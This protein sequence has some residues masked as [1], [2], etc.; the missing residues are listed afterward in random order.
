MVAMLTRTVITI[1]ASSETS[2]SKLQDIEKSIARV[3]MVE[4]IRVLKTQLGE[5]LH[6]VREETLRQKAD[7]QTAMEALQHELEGSRERMGGTLLRAE[8]G[9]GHRACRIRT[10]LSRRS[11]LPHS[12]PKA[13]SYC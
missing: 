4:D 1:G 6:T 11:R 2:V 12:R 10:R 5:C 7:R 13:T 3:R 9:P 8:F